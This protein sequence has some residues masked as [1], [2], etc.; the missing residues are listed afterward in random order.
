[1]NSRR[2]DLTAYALML[3]IASVVL[4]FI[5]ITAA[6]TFGADWAR[7]TSFGDFDLSGFR[8][9]LKDSTSI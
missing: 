4:V 9:H 3:L 2:R 1:M 8:A 7:V 6:R 5:F